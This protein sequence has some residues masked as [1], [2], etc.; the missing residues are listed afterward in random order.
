VGIKISRKAQKLLDR[1]NKPT[2][3]TD[4][5]L[6]KAAD[7]LC[8]LNA[9]LQKL[10]EDKKIGRKTTA[11]DLENAVGAALAVKAVKNFLGF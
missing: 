1:I 3:L 9:I 7:I 11:E 2:G 10:K 6:D 4:K 8:G 5:Q